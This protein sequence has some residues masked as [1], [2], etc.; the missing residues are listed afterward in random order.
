MSIEVPEIIYNLMVNFTVTLSFLLGLWDYDKCMLLHARG[1]SWNVIK[2]V[3]ASEVEPHG[4]VNDLCEF[5]CIINLLYIVFSC[6][7]MYQQI[8]F[9]FLTGSVIVHVFS[10]SHNRSNDY[11]PHVQCQ[12]NSTSW[13]CSSFFLVQ[14]YSGYSLLLN[15]RTRSFWCTS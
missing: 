7:L 11:G 15:S 10:D 9:L 3:P 1:R 2:H 12:C 13:Y 4:R 6:F 8:C 14:L 5:F